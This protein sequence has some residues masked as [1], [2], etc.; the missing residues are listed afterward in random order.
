MDW[1][2]STSSQ[3]I[4]WL[5]GR[6]GTGKSTIARTIAE[7]LHQQGIPLA[8]FFFKRGGGDLARSRKVISTIVFQLA[9]QLDILGRII[10]DTLQKEPDL[11]ESAALLEQFNKLLVQPLEKVARLP[12]GSKPIMIILD[13]LDECDDIDDIRRLLGRFGRTQSLSA[14]GIRLLVTSRPEMPIQLGFQNMDHIT[15]CELALHDMPR[16]LVD[17]DIETYITYRL[18]QIQTDQGL[19][20][21]WPNIDQIRKV[22]ELADGLFIYAAT[23]RWIRCT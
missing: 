19:P 8:S 7:S 14:L 12:T 15:Y 5:K 6:A 1:T 17:R 23:M 21:T 20:N 11:G 9:H 16:A 18:G 22:T 4:F 10:C 2:A 13:A 3:Y